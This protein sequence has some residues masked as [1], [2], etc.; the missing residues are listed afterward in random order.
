MGEGNWWANVDSA[1]LSPATTPMLRPPS[2]WLS[3]A[4]VGP[5]STTG[6]L[7]SP[8]APPTIATPPPTFASS[9]P[10][11]THVTRPPQPVYQAAPRIP[12]RAPM[13]IEFLDLT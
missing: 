5:T 9:F 13:L 4:S 2:Q 3:A 7:L 12:R 8:E 1:T 10:N 6:A 11:P